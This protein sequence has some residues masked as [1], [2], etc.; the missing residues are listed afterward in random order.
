M[1]DQT[2]RNRFLKYL[3]GDFFLL[4][5]EVTIDI[6]F[7]MLCDFR[8]QAIRILHK[9]LLLIHELLSILGND[10]GV[11]SCC[12]LLGWNSELSFL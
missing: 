2:C 8:R 5:I 12:S 9:Y 3:A 1:E 6:L 10:T 4:N 11:V 7:R